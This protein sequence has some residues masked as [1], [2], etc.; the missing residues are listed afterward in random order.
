MTGIPEIFADLRA[1]LDAIDALMP[2]ADK[3]P[4]VAFDVRV[5][6]IEP[7]RLL[8]LLTLAM[9][10]G[11]TE[12]HH[13]MRITAAR[14]LWI[15]NPYA[16]AG[17]GFEAL[18]GRIDRAI[19][20]RAK[21]TREVRDLVYEFCPNERGGL[22]PIWSDFEPVIEAEKIVDEIIAPMSEEV[23]FDMTVRAVLFDCF[24]SDCEGGLCEGAISFFF[25]RQPESNH[26]KLA[27]MARCQ[28]LLDFLDRAAMFKTLRRTGT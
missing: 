23:L 10:D 2:A 4:D 18:A 19:L 26:E 15:D 1:E 8:R 27:Q 9:F 7:A 13:V 25:A 12:L 21:S 3:L 14:F 16:T 5:R 28:R 17:P 24:T 20:H 11:R 22:R 6:A